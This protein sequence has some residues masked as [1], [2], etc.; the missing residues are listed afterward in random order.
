M[1]TMMETIIKLY[2]TKLVTDTMIVI[3]LC[4]V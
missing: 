4:C 2:G 3:R 1:I